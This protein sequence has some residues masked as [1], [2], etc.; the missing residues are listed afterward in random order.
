MKKAGWSYGISRILQFIKEPYTCTQ[1]P[2]VRLKIFY[3]SWSLRPIVSSPWM[4][5]IGMWVI[6]V[7]TVPCLCYGSTSG[8]QAW[9]IRYRN[10]LN[11]VVTCPKHSKHPIV[12]TTLMDLLCVDFTSIEMTLELNRLPKV[13]NVLVFQDHFTKHVMA[14]VNPNQTAKIVT[15]FLCQCYISIFRALARLLSDW[16][17]KFMSSIIDEMCKLLGVKKLWTMPYH[18]QT[19]GLVERSHQTIM[20]M[21]RTR[22]KTK[23]LTGQ[24]IWLK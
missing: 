6:M 15:K 17:A 16:G 3:S 19:N 11:P 23:R 5:A 18:P 1:C 21:I 7:V 13:S 9:Q 2:K 8:G 14:Y 20:Q 22:E 12:A 10:P 4:G 24:D